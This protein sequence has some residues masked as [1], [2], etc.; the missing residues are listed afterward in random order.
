MGAPAWA[1]SWP[2]AAPGNTLALRSW[3][4]EPPQSRGPR[5]RELVE[6]IALTITWWKD[7]DAP[8]SWAWARTEARCELI[9]EWLAEQGGDLHD[10]ETVRPRPTCC[11]GWTEADLIVCA[12]K[13]ARCWVAE[14]CAWQ[15]VAAERV[16]CELL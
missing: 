13:R 15:S 10:D 4:L 8:A 2:A 1:Y 6:R 5:A 7:A 12:L 16:A 3:R 9:A 14:R 11:S